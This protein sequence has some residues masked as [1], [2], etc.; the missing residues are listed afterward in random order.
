MP[1]AQSYLVCPRCGLAVLQEGDH[2]GS[3]LCRDCREA[4]GITVKMEQLIVPAAPP[5][6]RRD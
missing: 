3:P 1:Q 5:P 4:D 6:T 2:N